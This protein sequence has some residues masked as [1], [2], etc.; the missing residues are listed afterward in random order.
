MVALPLSVLALAAGVYLLVKI[1]REFLGSAFELLAWLV[2]VLAV[3][4]VGY[5]AFKLLNKCGGSCEAKQA[6]HVEKEVVIKQ[7]GEGGGTC[8]GMAKAECAA[9]G[10]AA[11]CCK[12]QGDSVVMDQ[13]TCAGM[14][15]KEQCEAMRKERGQCIL[16]KAECEALCAKTGKSCCAADKSACAAGNK[17]KC[18]KK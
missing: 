15:G 7:M 3:A 8:H 18:C 14:M 11:S 17:E 4:S 5:T 1:K 2:I 6:C 12:M 16:S 13:A 10:E 9:G